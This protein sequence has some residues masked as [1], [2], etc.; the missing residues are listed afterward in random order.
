MVSDCQ[1]G[2]RGLQDHWKMMETLN[3]RA[4]E[5]AVS[6]VPACE[7]YYRSS[8]HGTHIKKIK[9]KKQT[10]W[11]MPLIPALGRQASKF[12]VSLVYRVGSRT[13]RLRREIRSRNKT[14]QPT[15]IYI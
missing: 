14:N 8:H 3:L 12:E 4:G 1:C 13:T 15:Y 11:H 9:K 10:W 5:M 7:F 2:L 6:K